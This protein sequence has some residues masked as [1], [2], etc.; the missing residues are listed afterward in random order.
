MTRN[1]LIALAWAAAIIGVAAAGRS[2]MIEA[3][4]A[5]TLTMVMPILAVLSI[6]IVCRTCK[7]QRA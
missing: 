6:G 7:E 1:L 4:S 2:G 3:D 5:R